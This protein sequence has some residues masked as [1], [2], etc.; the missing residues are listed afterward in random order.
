MAKSYSV[1]GR[2]VLAL[3]VPLLVF[4]AATVIVLDDDYR[5]L[6]DDSMRARLEEQL[7]VLISA[8]RLE[9][10][11]RVNLSVGEPDVRGVVASPSRFASIRDAQGIPL[12]QSRSLVRAGF[13]L[14]P[15]PAEGPGRFSYRLQR[16][17]ERLAVYSRGRL[18]ENAPGPAVLLAFSV[19]EDTAAQRQQRQ[20]FREALIGGFGGLALLLLTALAW[21]LRRGLEPLRRLEREI[22]QLEGGART[23]LSGPWPRELAGVAEN[24]NTLLESERSRIARYRDS[25]GNLAHG[26]KTPLAVMRAALASG[27]E[28][29]AAVNEQIDRMTKIIDHQLQRAAGGGAAALGQVPVA[30]APLA[31]ELRAALLRVHGAKDLLIELEIE[32]GSGFAGDGG[33]LTELLGNLLDNACK[34]S[35]SR[36]RLRAGIEASAPPALRLHLSVED[37]GPGIA[38]ADRER[39]L[40]RGVRADEGQPGHGLGLA[41]VRETVALY[42][43]QLEIDRSELGG[44]RLTL[45][46]PG[47][48]IG[49][50]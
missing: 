35:R 25:L 18:L 9:A 36:V 28:S 34:W 42:G 39:V 40:G 8:V 46:L 31:A 24:L 49:A 26:L 17:G 27:R 23:A 47:R 14:G 45:R 37:D 13:D 12:W 15:V 43:G 30:V 41:M 19:A 2:L 29:V 32:P 33:D 50:T 11:G 48:A 7:E 10:D 20:R 6:A 44:A 5:R 22:A 3:A 16:N 38:P 1:T 21:G 4:F